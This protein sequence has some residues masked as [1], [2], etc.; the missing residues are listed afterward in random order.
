MY[1]G[2]DEQNLSINTFYLTFY[3]LNFL[4]GPDLIR[5]TLYR[6]N[7]RLYTNTVV[8]C[9]FIRPLVI[10]I[11]VYIYLFLCTRSFNTKSSDRS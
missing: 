3:F 5:V 7:S 10:Y 1:V 6:E 9:R 8:S 11:H 2:I 4:H